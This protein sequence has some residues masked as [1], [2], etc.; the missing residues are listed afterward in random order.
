MGVTAWIARERD[1]FSN[2]VVKDTS[3]DR[4]EDKK[5]DQT[6][7]EE[8]D[9]DHRND[10]DANERLAD[11]NLKEEE[12]PDIVDLLR[13]QDLIPSVAAKD[14][15]T[16]LDIILEAIRYIDSLQDKLADKIEKG[17]IVPLQMTGKRKREV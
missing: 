13:L 17:E 4:G 9:T 10:N 14:N 16:H 7:T 2:M 11:D 6:N 8:R 12:E 15:V 5:G 3:E 1:V